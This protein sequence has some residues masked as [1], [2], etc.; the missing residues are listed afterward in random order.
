MGTK[1]SIG[2]VGLG[3][4]GTRLADRMQQLGATIEAG[5]DVSDEARTAFASEFDAAPFA[6]HEELLEEASIDGLVVATPNL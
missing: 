1:P 4:M 6:D 2:V 5:A 3:L